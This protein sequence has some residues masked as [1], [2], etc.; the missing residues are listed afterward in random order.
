MEALLRQ[1]TR[2]PELLK[3]NFNYGIRELPYPFRKC[4]AQCHKCATANIGDQVRSRIK[5]SYDTKV[6]DTEIRVA[7]F[8]FF[9]RNNDDEDENHVERNFS[10]Q[11]SGM[12]RSV[13]PIHDTN[14]LDFQRHIH[15]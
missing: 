4:G 1:F 6:E 9:I 7:K 12:I 14:L 2:N 15:F 10:S 8:D 11:M 13:I 3:R 5:N